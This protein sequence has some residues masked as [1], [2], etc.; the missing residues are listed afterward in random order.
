MTVVA[1][2]APATPGAAGA[3]A[4]AWPAVAAGAVDD[5]ADLPVSPA[6]DPLA[7]V[8][9]PVAA[10][11]LGGPAVGGDFP[12][13]V[14]TVLEPAP[15]EAAGGFAAVAEATAVAAGAGPVVAVGEAG[16][17]GT[18]AVPLADDGAGPVA[19]AVAVAP[20]LAFPS[21][22]GCAVGVAESCP[23]G[24]SAALGTATGAGCGSRVS[25]R[26]MA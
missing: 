15:P 9:V 24:A 11:P 7:G 19:G 18:R 20:V 25:S 23:A 10:W 26:L 5:P 17:A 13:T 6:P 1:P 12:G 4:V 14:A 22:G 8:G 3:V 16:L 21:A 2:E